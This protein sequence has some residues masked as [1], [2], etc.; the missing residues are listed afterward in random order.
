M[1]ERNNN[2]PPFLALC[3]LTGVLG[4]G[5]GIEQREEFKLKMSLSYR[6]SSPVKLLEIKTGFLYLF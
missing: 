1:K 2:N 6:L 3:P 5:A 4:C